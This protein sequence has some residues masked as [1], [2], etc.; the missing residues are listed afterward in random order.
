MRLTPGFLG[1]LQTSCVA[2]SEQPVEERQQFREGVLRRDGDNEFVLG[3]LRD[4][5][6]DTGCGFPHDSTVGDGARP[7]VPI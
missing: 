5:L 7:P 4:S 6:E 1:V 2:H 3:P